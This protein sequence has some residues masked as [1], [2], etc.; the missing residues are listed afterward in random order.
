M[1]EYG[2]VDSHST[3]VLV[4]VRSSTSEVG[5]SG[6]VAVLVPSHVMITESPGRDDPELVPGR[7]LAAHVRA[8]PGG[9]VVVIS[10][11]LHD[12]VGLSAVNLAIFW[13][14]IQGPT[15]VVLGPVGQ[16]GRRGDLQPGGQ[17]RWW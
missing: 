12:S 3:A 7:L 9:G 16:S 14:L 4:V 6:G 8:G 2:G 13:E 5:P 17:R 11:Y 1:Y 10:V 15:D